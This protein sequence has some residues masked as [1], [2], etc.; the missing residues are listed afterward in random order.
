MQVIVLPQEEGWRGCKAQN[1]YKKYIWRNEMVNPDIS[2]YTWVLKFE[3]S[4][5]KTKN[6][7]RKGV[8][9][10]KSTK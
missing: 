1:V 2:N 5:L 3:D 6:Y 8:I 4:I 9:E 10:K 7:F